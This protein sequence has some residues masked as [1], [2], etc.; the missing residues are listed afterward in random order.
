MPIPDPFVLLRERGEIGLRAALE[1]L[2]L[3]TLRQLVR[4]HHLDPA[5][6]SARW[7]AR[8]RVVTL[9]VTQVQ[10]RANHGKAFARV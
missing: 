6:I 8:D 5:R 4:A 1:E 7:T 2:E 9:I 10:A 3:A